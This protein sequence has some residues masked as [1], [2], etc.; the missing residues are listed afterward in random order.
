VALKELPENSSFIRRLF[1]DVLKN[2]KQKMEI[3]ANDYLRINIRH[4]SLDSE[5]WLEFTQSKNLDEDKILGKIE[6]VQQSKREFLLTD[7]ATELDFFHVKYPQGSGGA[8]MKHL[9]LD[10]EK[11]KKSK[12]AIIR[13]NNPQDS[14]C[15]PRAIVVARCQAV[16]Q[17]APLRNAP[18]AMDFLKMPPV[19]RTI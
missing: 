7:G 14:L 15:L 18:I 5:I 10:K 9:Y 19:S 12:R 4:P 16:F 8:K 17:T 11:F 13:I 6:A 1:G 2:V 3:S